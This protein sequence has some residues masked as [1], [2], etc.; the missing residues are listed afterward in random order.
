MNFLSEENNAYERM[1]Q[2]GA[3]LSGF[4]RIQGVKRMV[5]GLT[6]A[7]DSFVA[8][9]KQM[10]RWSEDR[11]VDYDI[12]ATDLEQVAASLPMSPQSDYTNSNPTTS[13]TTTTTDETT[14]TAR[15]GK[16]LL[17]T[18]CWSHQFGYTHGI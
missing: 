6:N 5:P 9:Q 10:G 1:V 11:E 16:T 15:K 3:E 12:F 17:P 13:T 8:S 18:H 4:F 2:A 7:Y 14:T